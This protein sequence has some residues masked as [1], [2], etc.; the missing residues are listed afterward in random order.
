[1]ALVPSGWTTLSVMELRLDSLFVLVLFLVLITVYTVK[2]LERD[3]VPLTVRNHHRAAGW[4]K[5][6][7]VVGLNVSKSICST[8]SKVKIP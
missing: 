2:M 7:E 6:G 1:M 5:S 3:V 8:R 4:L